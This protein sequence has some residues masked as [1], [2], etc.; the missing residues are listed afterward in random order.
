[1]KTS[2]LIRMLGGLASLLL[3]LLGIGT[4]GNLFPNIPFLGI[5]GPM[6]TGSLGLWTVLLA[7]A[8]SV[9]AFLRWRRN[10]RVQT[11]LV[12]A[13]AAF[14]TAGLSYV[15]VRQ[16][17]VAKAHGVQIS[18]S[19]ALFARSQ[20]D[21]SLKPETVIYAKHNGQN[22]PID[23][24]SPKAGSGGKAAPV[25]IYIH[26]GGWGAE[27]LKQRQADYRWFAE[28]GYVVMSFEY[29]L[30]S[31]SQ[32]TWNVTHPLLGCALVWAN[33]NAARFGGDA[34]R[35]AIW[36]ESAGGNLVLNLSYKANG[37]TLKPSCPGA[38]PVIRATVALYPI[39]D[40]VRM[41]HNPDP[42]T[43]IFARMMT[44]RYTGGTPKQFPDRY[45]EIAPSTHVSAKAP[46]T[47]LIIPESDHLLKADA[48]DAFEAKLHAAGIKTR[49]IH[50]PY[51]EHSFD[52]KS[53]SIGNQRVRQAMLKFLE[54][55]SLKP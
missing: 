4:L 47:L 50:V 33:A 20:S 51:A 25:F 39:I 52:I 11:L 45:T 8:G 27:T 41:Y 28:R 46:S 7:L 12:A 31:E 5:I 17:G 48:A 54:H 13:L 35:I 43:G 44:T 26:G 3:T 22:L 10:R 55:Q 16:I 32:A 36:G 6:L 38:L 34:S 49:L 23:V 2:L 9:W 29:P 40:P 18:L 24:Y 15:P 37:G 30:A 1:M 14:A 19:E 21:D 42:V 53:G